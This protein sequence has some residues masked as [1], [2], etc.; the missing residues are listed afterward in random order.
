[1]IADPQEEFVQLAKRQLSVMRQ[2]SLFFSQSSLFEDTSWELLLEIFVACEEAGY[3]SEADLIDAL[4]AP[5]SIVR[6]WLTVFED[7]GYIKFLQNQG[8]SMMTITDIAREECVSFLVTLSNQ[9]V[10]LPQPQ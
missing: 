2:R 1:M 4:G 7:C 9:N 6:R 5:R 8:S 10:H 3:V